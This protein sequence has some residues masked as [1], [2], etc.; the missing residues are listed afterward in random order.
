MSLQERSENHGRRLAALSTILFLFLASPAHSTN[1]V[2]GGETTYQVK[3]GDT[4]QLIGARYGVFWKNIAAL[5]KLDTKILPPAGATL[6][7][8]TRKIV[9]KVLED[10]LVVNIADRTLYFLKE[11]RLLAIPVGVGMLADD[12]MDNDWKTSIGKFVI[13]GKR[14]DPT[15][16]VPAS[17]QREMA[18]KGKPVEEIVPPGP[19]NPLGRYALVTS[20]LG[21]LIHETIKPGSVYRY[22]SHGCIRVLPEHMEELF[23]LVTVGTPGEFIYEPVKVAVTD[24]GKVYV[25]VRTDAYSKVKPLRGHTRK[26]IDAHGLSDKVDWVKVDGLV[27][28][29][30]GI[31]TDVTLTPE[32][33]WRSVQGPPPRPFERIFASLKSLWR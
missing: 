11:G 25:E 24:Q 22:T 1:M 18:M 3:K 19:D 7:I 29:E 16:R 12:G 26:I 17:I 6:T 31:A 21:L 13:V 27:K 32:G 15:W 8:N 33:M 23:P 9:P 10:G 28:S 2:I 20:I 4:L 30:S 14:K 5:N